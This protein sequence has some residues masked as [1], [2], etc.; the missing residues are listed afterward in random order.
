VLK[1]IRIF[2]INQIGFSRKEAN[3]TIILIMILLLVLI[4]PIFYKGLNEQSEFINADNQNLLEW[5]KEISESIRKK[6]V[7]QE[8]INPPIDSFNPNKLPKEKWEEFGFSTLISDRIINYLK[9][10]G[11]FYAP[12]DLYK[13]YGIDSSL[14]STIAPYISI[15]SRESRTARSLRPTSPPPPHEKNKSNHT[16][17]RKNLNLASQEDLMTIR[18]I[19]EKLSNRIKRYGESLGGY[20]HHNQLHEVYYLDDSII[21]II[22]QHF[23]IDSTYIRPLN[24]NKD[25]ISTLKTHPYLTYNQARAIVNYRNVHGDFKSIDVIKQVKIIPD[26]TYIKLIPYLSIKD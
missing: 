19:G 20:H 9:A 23:H 26:S 8:I 6:P 17:V 1:R 22:Q 14:V 18:G 3:G 11:R 2:I 16:I 21:P 7:K 4:A 10:G 25:S 24:L 5:H 15:P 13:I 12:N